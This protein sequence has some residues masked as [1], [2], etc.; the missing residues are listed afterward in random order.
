MREVLDGEVPGQPTSQP[1][2]FQL[3][4]EEPGG[5]RPPCLGEPRGPQEKVQQHT[6]EQLADVVF[7]VQILDIPGPQGENHLV[8]A[9][10]HVDLPIPEPKISSSSRRCRLRGVRIVRLVQQT[11]EQL[12]E[13]RHSSSSSSSSWSGRSSR[14]FLRTEF[15]STVCGAE[16]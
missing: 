3:F 7:M 2:L 9:F 8:E 13:V 10:R 4:E 6:V 5:S 12:V 1:E 15:N 14:F 16:R 11:A